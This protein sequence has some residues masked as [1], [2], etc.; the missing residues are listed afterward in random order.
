MYYQLPGTVFENISIW[1]IS[2]IKALTN[3]FFVQGYLILNTFHD[4]KMLV[5]YYSVLVSEIPEYVLKEGFTL[6]SDAS[7]GRLC[8]ITVY[9]VHFKKHAVNYGVDYIKCAEKLVTAWKHL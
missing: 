6:F 1:T 7:Q 9:K 8:F 3:L 4:T 5:K 2:S